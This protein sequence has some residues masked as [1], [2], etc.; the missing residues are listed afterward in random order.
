MVPRW[1]H[2][3]QA[4]KEAARATRG[5]L[6]QVLKELFTQPAVT[7]GDDSV[8]AF[9]SPFR[10]FL[11]ATDD[12]ASRVVDRTSGPGEPRAWDWTLSGARFLK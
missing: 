11:Q 4:Y 9:V 10:H 8:L 2:Q 6:V 3:R 1:A 7:C 12:P 5:G